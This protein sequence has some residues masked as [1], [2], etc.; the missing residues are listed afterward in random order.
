MR[1]I[2]VNERG[3]TAKEGL[4]ILITWDDGCDAKQL[5]IL[6]KYCCSAIKNAIS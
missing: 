3:K 4:E 6:Y 5:S 2:E 1:W